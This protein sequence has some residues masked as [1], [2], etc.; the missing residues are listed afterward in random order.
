MHVH[1]CYI[2][3]YV[4]LLFGKTLLISSFNQGVINELW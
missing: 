3:W 2:P 4:L 1:T